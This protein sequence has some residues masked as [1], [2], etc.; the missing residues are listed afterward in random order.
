M[1]AFGPDTE[2]LSTERVA[3]ELGVTTEWV[4][5]QIGAGRLAARRF[6]TGNRAF[7]RVRRVDV[8]RF[9]AMY[10]RILGPT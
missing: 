1:T 3:S 5:R 10:T 7:Y 9:L 2:W 4:R 6:E 8:E